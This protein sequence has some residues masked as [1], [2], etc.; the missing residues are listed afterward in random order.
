MTKLQI[1]S[2]LWSV[3]YD[4]IFIINGKEVKSVDQIEAEMDR[5]E[6]ECRKYDEADDIEEDK[7]DS[8]KYSNRI[9]AQPAVN[10]NH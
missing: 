5:L 4:L 10:K 8:C 1:I 7:F 3:I 9:R 6:Y 2:R